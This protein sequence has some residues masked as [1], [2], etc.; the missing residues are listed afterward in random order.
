MSEE[1]SGAQLR[2]RDILEEIIGLRNETTGLRYEI[3]AETWLLRRAAERAIEIISE[4]SR[5]IPSEMKDR[6]PNVP[7]RQIAGVGN[8]LRH[9]YENISSRVIWDIIVHHLDG[10]EAAVRR[11]LDTVET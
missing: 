9:D 6:E 7:W 10:L 8:V 4:A 1:Q 11:L 2:L 5:H 3:F